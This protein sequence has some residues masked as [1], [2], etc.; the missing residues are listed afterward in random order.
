MVMDGSTFYLIV[1]GAIEDSAASSGTVATDDDVAILGALADT[2][3]LSFDGHLAMPVL[4]DGSFTRRQV[5]RLGQWRRV[6]H[7]IY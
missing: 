6:L 3:Q 2:G 5:D 4:L 1:D 7:G